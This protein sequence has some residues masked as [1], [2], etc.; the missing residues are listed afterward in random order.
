MGK[1]CK[2]I[3]LA[4]LFSC[5]I[6]LGISSCGTDINNS[7]N[8]VSSQDSTSEVV[9]N[10]QSSTK[11]DFGLSSENYSSLEETS[12]DIISN[13]SSG[14]LSSE[15]MSEEISSEENI[16]SEEESSEEESLSSPTSEET[17]EVI[18]SES[19]EELSFE[20]TSE[21]TSE[22]IVSSEESSSDETSSEI[23]SS[24]T[25][26]ETSSEEIITSEEVSSE[27]SSSEEISIHNHNY[28]EKI[29]DP[30][31]TEQ[32]YTIFTCECGD[33]Y[34]GNFVNATGH[35]EIEHEG[36][37]ATCKEAG[38]EPYVT[39]ENCEYSTYTIITKLEHSYEEEIVDPTCTEQ[40]YT[41]FTCEC[42][43]SYNGNFVN[44]TGH[45]EI[46]HE[47][48]E[49]TCIKEGY[50][51][52]VTCENCEYST[53]TVIAKLD[54]SYEEEI[55]DPTCTGEGYTIFTCE[56]GD[57]YKNNY[58]K[59][60][61]HTEVI[62]EAVEAT[63]TSTGL[64]QG[65]HCD[66]CNEI[67]VKQREVS[68]KN[69][70]WNNGEITTP[71][72]C[73][74]N[75]V[76][77]YTCISCNGTKTSVINARGYHNYSAPEYF[78]DYENLTLT[79]KCVCIDDETHIILETV[80]VVKT[81]V[82]EA[83]CTEQ[84]FVRYTSDNF[85]SSYLY[86]QV[87]S[88]YVD[89]IPHV[90]TIIPGTPATCTEIGLTDGEYCEVC[91]QMVVNQFTISPLGHTEVIDARVDPTCTE[92]GLTEGKHCGDCNIIITYQESI[93]PLG[94][95]WDEGVITIPVSCTYEGTKYFTCSVCGDHK[96]EQISTI[97]HVEV[98]DLAV[99]PTCTERG[100]T[101]GS[102]C[103]VCNTTLIAQT[104]IDA[105]GHS[106]DEGT[107]TKQST[108]LEAG[109]KTYECINCDK[110]Q[111]ESISKLPHTEVIDA[112]VD[113]TCEET[114]L[115]QGSHCD[116]CGT[117]LV[118]QTTIA[119]T[120]HNWGQVTYEWSLDY[121]HL[122]ASCVCLNDESHTLT[123]TVGTTQYYKNYSTCKVVG[124]EHYLSN[125][126]VNSVFSQQSTIVYLPLLEHKT[127]V[128][129]KVEPTC[130]ET[131]LTEG[132]YCT[133]C[134][135]IFIEQEVIPAL[136]HIEVLDARVNPTC[137]ETGLTEGSHCLICNKVFIEQEVINS[138]GHTEVI[139]ELVSAT[140]IESGLTEG[141]H[142]STCNEIL[143]AQ[144][145]IPA[146]GHIEVI[147]EAVASTCIKSGLTEG[148]HCSVCDEILIAQNVIP[149][150]GH[151]EVIDEAIA[152]TCTE[153]GL[154]QGK[155][156]L[157]CNEILIAQNIIP[158]LGHIEVIDEAVLATCTESGLTQGSHCEVCD[159]VLAEQQIIA[160]R[161][162]HNY[163]AYVCLDCGKEYNS[164]FIENCNSRYG[165][166]YLGQLSNG[167][168]LQ[169]L[170]L[171]IDNAVK[172]VHINELLDI[173]LINI[174]YS[175]LNITTEEA[176]SVWKTYRDDNPLYYW[177]SNT[178]EYNEN[179]LVINVIDC[180]VE[181]LERARINEYIYSKIEEYAEVASYEDSPYFI[182]L[183][184]HDKIIDTISYAYE[185]DGVT[186]E[187][188][189]WAHSIIGVFDMESGVC[190][191]Y[192]R[193]FQLL[194]NYCFV[195]NVFV[196]GSANDENHAW[197]LVKLD[198]NEWYWFDLTWDD[199]E[200][201]YSFGESGR[202]WGISYDYFA[203]NTNSDFELTHES[204]NST[205]SDVKFLYELPE[206]SSLELEIDYM[207][208]DVFKI[209]RL[210]YLIV[211]YDS[212]E[213]TNIPNFS[214]EE[215]IIIPESLFYR[216]RNYKIISI[217]RYESNL[218]FQAEYTI[219]KDIYLPSTI[220]FIWDRALSGICSNF[221]ISE[222]NPY[223]TSLDG[224]LFTKNL[225]TLISYPMNNPRKEYE[226]PD[227]TRYVSDSAFDYWGDNGKLEK[228][229]IGKNVQ[230]LG[231]VNWGN[232][233]EFL[234][235]MVIGGFSDIYEELAGEKIITVSEDNP[236]FYMYNNGIYSCDKRYLYWVEKNVEQFVI[237]DGTQRI[238]PNAFID[239][240]K[241]KEVTIPET[242]INI[243][244]GAFVN[245]V[246][247]KSVTLPKSLKNI[248]HYLFVDCNSLEEIII[249]G[250]ITEIGSHAF[251]GCEK[252]KTI[253][254]TS[255]IVIEKGS[256]ENGY[257]GYYA[258]NIYNKGEWEYIDGVPTPIN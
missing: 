236:Y 141:K 253:Y 20:T 208:G 88:T 241:L 247:L 224:V 142:C 207:L 254:N 101:Q 250:N 204:D 10:S 13:E 126:F 70:S 163:S 2:R 65:S 40:G 227:E 82:A 21:A 28:E 105:T 122:T 4:I 166:D 198:N 167:S 63:C 244:S 206:V 90:T 23:I 64:T 56:C 29:V 91:E 84:G 235:N 34:N 15:N 76:K 133:T 97:P 154:T 113:S 80:N 69:H 153:S 199:T 124:E 246:S 8:I 152:P 155:H 237:C 134:G 43:D 52:Y 94:H 194:L 55:V 79:G 258:E 175:S 230:I 121:Q 215:D 59:A 165:Y 57:T 95:S 35:S 201:N 158:A 203:C 14:E 179:I 135:D 77:T 238:D 177:M 81:V 184:L 216:G 170:Y 47:G 195:E 222:D 137:E 17:S 144:N 7:S 220:R 98:I 128:L 62:D 71:A 129:S 48:K 78:W 161:N 116:V 202:R 139:D 125:V 243:E 73:V 182:A 210:E 50:E 145:I 183:A 103:G 189:H 140:C 173:A 240:T 61:G 85:A 45:S 115:T 53:Y 26:E 123:E 83:T 150:L 193:T 136:G 31:C 114:G 151:I 92:R 213:I 181:G 223:F 33:T 72:S 117:T 180:Y 127:K 107:I 169:Q 221:Y 196:T 248:S 89:K 1:K 159:F 191:S 32:G 185:E 176:L 37:E 252:L 119:A 164:I 58:V 25:S 162:V 108:C 205:N 171:N 172:E 24:E 249:L 217:N 226:I 192:A 146:L 60:L 149:A 174:D 187:S 67:I 11:E 18:S 42:G 160:T 44:V 156:C 51:P 46:E 225:G 9:E 232:G 86:F 120:G 178:I 148:K 211:G 22:E 131:G 3:P 138:L 218:E 12:S 54:H 5:F 6:V 212:L 255:D 245:C 109:A 190:E 143:I 200:N 132:L 100:L 147:D 157:E 102:H 93:S 96:Y 38:Y 197:N 104:I 39:C 75:G 41:I 87:Y 239:C 74:E 251:Y 36:K 16:S 231:M 209:E 66:I 186:P 188:E 256:E 214:L 229:I 30:T 110:T 257:L 111:T 68:T 27:E 19:S 130:E 228:L 168:D 233:Y 112:R 219:C 99:A 118:A 234:M 242:V 106:W 49:A